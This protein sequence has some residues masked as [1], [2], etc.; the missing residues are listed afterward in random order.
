MSFA[1][2]PLRFLLLATTLVAFAPGVRAGDA[3]PAPPVSAPV[4]GPAATPSAVS[5]LTPEEL[6]FVRRR[7]PDFDARDEAEREKIATNVLRLRSLSPEERKRLVERMQRVEGEGGPGAAA[8]AD[9]L[10][11]IKKMGRASFHES[12][13]R[14]RAVSV[15]VV[16]WLSA[17]R[18]GVLTPNATPTSLGFYERLQLDVCIA[19][20]WKRRVVE[21]LVTKPPV[22]AESLA[23]TGSPASAKFVAA[24]DRVK[25]AG[26]VAA[27]EAE[28]RGYAMAYLEDRVAS[29]R[30]RAEGQAPITPSGAAPS[31][32][33]PA[34]EERFEAFGKALGE[35]FPSSIEAVVAELST[36]VDGGRPAL[37]KFCDDA[38]P[39]RATPR[40][41]VLVELVLGLERARLVVVGD[42]LAKLCDLQIAALRELKVPESDLAKFLPGGDEPSRL[43]VLAP[44]AR[45]ARS[46]DRGGP[47]GGLR[48]GGGRRDK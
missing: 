41:R 2:A 4:P 44:F 27:P 46:A 18:R 10:A 20:A 23:A 1:R 34:S 19:T 33:A 36:A 42:V 16:A 25:A 30:R 48:L 11:Q 24:R 40:E 21:G 14:M 5:R 32:G 7:L 8:A 22:D 17:E 39:D 45:R 15:A 28:R 13:L 9:R 43:L 38:M 37:K 3:P 12:T 6:A 35:A 47:H 31:P 26:G 29:A